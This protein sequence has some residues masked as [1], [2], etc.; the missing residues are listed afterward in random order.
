MDWQPP[1]R[2]LQDLG[3]EVALWAPRIDGARCNGCDACLHACAHDA[4]KLAPK[5]RAYVI[6]AAA[7]T[8]CNA[9]VDACDR[10]AVRVTAGAVV[11]QWR[12][13]LAEGRC[14]ACGAVFH[15][16]ERGEAPS[17]CPVCETSGHHRSLYQVL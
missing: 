4:L 13:V 15:R 2:M 7:C 1:G 5:S 17:L 16:P 12:I 11:E 9:C 6:D 10:A 8:G 3:P 14:R